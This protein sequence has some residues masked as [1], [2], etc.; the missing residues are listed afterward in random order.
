[1]EAGR[2]EHQG[3]RQRKLDRRGRAR[4]EAHQGEVQGVIDRLAW[5]TPTGG[6]AETTRGVAMM[7]RKPGRITRA[8]Y[9][10]LLANAYCDARVAVYD[11]P[12]EP[13]VGSGL[14]VTTTPVQ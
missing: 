14:D 2:E 5:T 6:D 12:Y 4:Q 13:P 3:D 1:M 10:R 7:S 8:P 9:R 11:E